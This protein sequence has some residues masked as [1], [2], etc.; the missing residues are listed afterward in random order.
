MNRMNYYSCRRH[1][2]RN[3]DTKHVPLSLNGLKRVGDNPCPR[4]ARGSEY[5][6]QDLY[7]L[8]KNS[9]DYHI[10]EEVKKGIIKACRDTNKRFRC[11]RSLKGKSE[12]KDVS[13]PS[14]EGVDNKHQKSPQ[15]RD[16]NEN[17][18]EKRSMKTNSRKKPSKDMAYF[19]V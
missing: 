13:T 11:K 4:L 9:N 19:S 2:T 15:K 18:P 1:P 3:I 14:A 10:K 7:F 16:S 5:M 17:P 12:L 8:Y 6:S